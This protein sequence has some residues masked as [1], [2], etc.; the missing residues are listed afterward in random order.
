MLVELFSTVAAPAIAP[1]IISPC[2]SRLRTLASIRPAR[3]W[4]NGTMVTISASRPNTLRKT[5]RRVRLEKPWVTKNCQAWRATPA[6]P[7]VRVTRQ[8]AWKNCTV[9]SAAPTAAAPARLS[10]RSSNAAVRRTTRMRR[11]RRK[12]GAGTN[13]LGGGLQDLRGPIEH[14][15]LPGLVRCAP[16]ARSTVLGRAVQSRPGRSR[17]RCATFP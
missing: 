8:A 6:K 3:T 4:F 15:K 5:M 2:T 9:C 1:A 11:A 16:L 13:R 7:S 17:R 12:R 14:P 10:H